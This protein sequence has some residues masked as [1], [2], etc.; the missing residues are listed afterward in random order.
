MWHTIGCVLLLCGYSIEAALC[1]CGQVSSTVDPAAL[2]GDGHEA[3]A[4]VSPALAHTAAAAT[5]DLHQALGSLLRKAAVGV[6][7]Q[8]RLRA[9]VVDPGVT[10]VESAAART[11]R[12]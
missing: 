1:E 5:A 10:G 12:W 7:E 3:I 6:V 9:G 2:A 4:E 11:G 8:W